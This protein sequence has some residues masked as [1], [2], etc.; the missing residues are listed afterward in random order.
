M[1]INRFNEILARVEQMADTIADPVARQAI[2]LLLNLVEELHAENVCLRAENQDLKNL[3]S[4]LKGEQ[5]KPRINGDSRRRD[6]STDD[7]R[8]Q[9]E[10]SNDQNAPGY[11]YKLNRDRL[12]K[13]QEQDLP[14]DLLISLKSLEK[15]TFLTQEDFLETL[16][17]IIGKDA[18]QIYKDKLLKHA[19]Y[20]KRNRIPKRPNIHIDREETCCVDKGLLPEDAR[21]VGYEDKVVQNI[22]IKSDNVKFKKEV[23]Y[24]PY[25]HKT[26]SGKVPV[27]YEG[28]FGPAINTQI[29]S[30]K[31][32]SNMSEPKILE[33]LRGFGVLIS[34]AYISG[35]LTGKN[36]MQVFH[37]EKEGLYRAGLEHGGYQQIDD[38]SCRVNGKNK[39]VQLLGNPLF[40]A[41]FTTDR[42]DR[43]TVLDLLRFLAPRFYMFNDEAFELLEKMNVYHTTIDKLRKMTLHAEALDVEQMDELLNK[44]FPNPPKGKTT[45]TRIME[46]CAIAFYHQETRIP[47]VET[48]ICDDAPQFKLITK[49]LGLCWVHDARHYKKLTP[50]V[51]SHKKEQ[52]KFKSKYWAYYRKLFEFK[53]EPS[54]KLAHSLQADFDKLFSTQTGYQQLDERIARSKAKK[55]ELLT[56][57]Q[58]PDIPLHNNLAENAARVQKR[59]QDV[60]LQTRTIAGTRAKDTMMSV[61]ETCKKLGVNALD[62][63]HDRVSRK[64]KMPS[65]AMVIEQKSQL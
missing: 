39:Y 9:A 28:E 51:E 23:Y 16:E 58:F 20:K 38:T 17:R 10:S 34:A 49:N 56:V 6:V 26:F 60:S 41:Y 32:V 35:Y 57:L 47:V 29:I 1:D 14:N 30:M 4:K 50:I 15:K 12:D 63:I 52:K 18:V 42:K 59:R 45:R 46:A 64:F 8:R 5:G 27:G 11:G 54:E 36:S 61:V 62:F 44:I 48:F 55:I 40:T 37:E 43:L 25:L 7:V 22:I 13:L 3:I 24:S 21:F 19:F 33:T 2:S 31:Y 65:L 53:K